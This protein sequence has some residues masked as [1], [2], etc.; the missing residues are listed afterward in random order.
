MAPPTPKPLHG[1]RVMLQFHYVAGLR[2][3][4]MKY[5]EAPQ[6]AYAT[7]QILANP[8]HTL[9]P[10]LQQRHK[11]RDKD[12]L[13]L[14]VTAST[15]N[16]RKI[17]RSKCVRRMREAFHEEMKER[18]LRPDG[19]TLGEG[20]PF[21]VGSLEIY[22]KQPL[23]DVNHGEVRMQMGLIIDRLV[24]AKKSRSTAR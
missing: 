16:S 24:K 8:F 2:I 3:C 4:G 19:R 13:W 21:L 14:A 5:F 17:L 6:P 23:L 7:A 15:M 11:E 22:A 1:Q 18:G 20:Q 12:T 9:N 10:V